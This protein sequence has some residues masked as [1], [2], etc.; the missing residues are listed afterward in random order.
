MGPRSYSGRSTRARVVKRRKELWLR[1]ANFVALVLAVRLRRLGVPDH[2]V[3]AAVRGVLPVLLR[4]WGRRVGSRRSPPGANCGPRSAGSTDAGHRPPSPASTSPPARICTPPTSLLRWPAVLP[5]RGPPSTRPPP[6]RCP[7]PG[8]YH[9][10]SGHCWS[11]STSG[12]ASFDSFE[13]AL[14]SSI[15]A[16]T[17]SQSSSSSGGRWRW[18]RRWWWRRWRRRRFM[19]SFAGAGAGGRGRGADR[20]RGRLQQ[21]RGADVRWTRRS[22]ASTQLTR[23]ASLIPSLVST[24]GDLRP[25]EKAVLGH[26][27]DA[28]MALTAAT[29]GKSVAQRSSA[30]TTVRQRDGAGAGARQTHP[31]LSVVEQLP[32]PAAEPRRHRGQTGVRPAV[33]QR[34]RRHGQLA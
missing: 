17:A 11:D 20:F 12:G 26:I 29:A 24:V 3:G 6:V 14:S 2:A 4:A 16:Y 21:V 33:L 19:V 18:W 7:E 23:R 1:L 22:A 8:W 28:Q 10:S 9:T 34:R 27:A 25:H 13:S 31:Q 5:P 30:E 15:G 32:E